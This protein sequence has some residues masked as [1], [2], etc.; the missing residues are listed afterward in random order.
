MPQ[1]VFKYVGVDSDG[2]LGILSRRLP[3]EQMN[4][5]TFTEIAKWIG[6]PECKATRMLHFNKQGWSAYAKGKAW[7]CAKS[8]MG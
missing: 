5:T 2:D 4:T 3:L 8:S 7:K 6:L 1:Y